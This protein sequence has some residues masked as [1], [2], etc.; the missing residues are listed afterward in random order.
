MVMTTPTLSSSMARREVI[1]HFFHVLGRPRTRS[2]DRLKTSSLVKQVKE[3]DRFI[4]VL[5]EAIL[6]DQDVQEVVQEELIELI[7]CDRFAAP[8]AGRSHPLMTN[9]HNIVDRRKIYVLH[10]VW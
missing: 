6:R 4:A 9:F 8:P 2:R 1:M 10:S 7:E 3:G 5:L